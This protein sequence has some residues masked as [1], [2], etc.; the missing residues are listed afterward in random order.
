VHPASSDD[1]ST[2]HC[3][4]KPRTD[5]DEP[6]STKKV[7]AVIFFLHSFI[8]RTEAR[9]WATPSNVAVAQ[10]REATTWI[11]KNGLIFLL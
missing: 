1:N 4:F 6:D 7:V 2:Y 11:W 9:V 3:R 8:P 5:S 10:I